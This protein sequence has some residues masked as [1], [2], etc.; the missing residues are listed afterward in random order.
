ML[1]YKGHNSTVQTHYT[2][3]F[4]TIDPDLIKDH[5][6]SKI[7]GLESNEYSKSITFIC[8]HIVDCLKYE[9]IFKTL[10]ISGYNEY[11]ENSN[12]IQTVYGQEFDKLLKQIAQMMYNQLRFINSD[13]VSM[14]I[15]QYR[16]SQYQNYPN[17][18][19]DIKANFE[20]RSMSIISLKF[21]KREHNAFNQYNL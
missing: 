10:G 11:I 12:Y 20:N 8:K 7:T 21:F 13:F 3:F 6:E 5:I 17:I 4:S 15:N 2:A 18:I 9:Q 19:F 14:F 1:H 16:L